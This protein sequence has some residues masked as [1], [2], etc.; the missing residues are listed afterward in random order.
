MAFQRLQ[1]ITPEIVTQG[2][3]AT[4]SVVSLTFAEDSSPITGTAD[5]R[6]RVCNSGTVANS[7]NATIAV[8]TGYGTS[9]KEVSANKEYILR[10]QNGGA[11]ATGTLTISGVVVEAETVT[12]GSR[13]YEFDTD[14]SVTS[15]NVTVDISANATASQGTLTINTKPQA[16]DTMTIGTRTYAFVA[17]GTAD[18]D[19]EISIGADVAAAKVNIVAAINGTDGWNNP[20]TKV[21]AAAFVGDDC[22]LT[23][24]IAGTSGDAIVTTET[25]TAGTNV[26]DAGTLGTTTAGVD[27]I[28]ADAV[29][30]LVSAITGDSSAVVSAADGTGDT[31][32][33][34]ALVSGADGNYAST[35]TMANGAFG[36]A[37]LTGGYDSV[38]GV[39]RVTVTDATAETVDLLVGP[40][41][42]NGKAVDYSDASIS[43]THA[44][45]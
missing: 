17:S 7:T 28:A 8:T 15:G 23:A 3:T 2:T 22:V 10:T 45:P 30:A 31:V 26:F 44:A 39:V 19:G 5:V 41:E 4:P 36:S 6:V 37:T 20:N 27:C 18:T 43:V 1:K 34:T 33:V 21:S 25:F 38:P 13:V 14:S 12:I 40:P 29:T 32:D 11:T 9:L 35:E 42:V 16:G 24:R